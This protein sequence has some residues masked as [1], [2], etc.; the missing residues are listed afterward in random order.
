MFSDELSNSR[1]TARSAFDPLRVLGASPTELLPILAT[2]LQL[3]LDSSQRQKTTTSAIAIRQTIDIF[4]TRRESGQHALDDADIRSPSRRNP[5][6]PPSHQ[7]KLCLA[8]K[9]NSFRTWPD[10]LCSA[11]LRSVS[12]SVSPLASRPSS[13]PLRFTMPI[14]APLAMG[15]P[16]IFIKPTES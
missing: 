15:D 7:N 5:S 4:L 2:L 9:K 3:A 14:P 10:V 11:N 13:I 8:S 6:C 12:K 16:E 1:G